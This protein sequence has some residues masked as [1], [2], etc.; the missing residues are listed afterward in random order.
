MDR[1][2]VQRNSKE[3]REGN[4]CLVWHR[5]KKVAYTHAKEFVF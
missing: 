3:R 2:F 4:V 5:E 1:N